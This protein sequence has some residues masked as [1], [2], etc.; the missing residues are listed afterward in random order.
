M[1]L[2]TVMLDSLR[3]DFVHC[4]GREEM[5]TPAMD[6]LASE[7]AFFTNA[8]AEAPTT[9]PARTA[10]FSGIYTFTNRPWM[11]LLAS[12]AHLAEWLKAHGY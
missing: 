6:R 4:Y 9:I 3:P 1:N 8:Y 5:Q 11:P 7:G 2:I 12:D 10:I